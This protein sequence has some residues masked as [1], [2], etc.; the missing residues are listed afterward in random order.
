MRHSF[1]NDI[2]I[3]YE[4]YILGI[5]TRFYGKVEKVD[6]IFVA[7]IQGLDE[8]RRENDHGAFLLNLRFGYNMSKFGKI[9]FIVNNVLN[10]EISY[11]PARME[12][13]LNFVLQYKITI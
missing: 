4:K 9:S 11:R 8:Y 3:E 1:K 2:E 12:A 5:D 10:S 13:P 6:D 7:Y